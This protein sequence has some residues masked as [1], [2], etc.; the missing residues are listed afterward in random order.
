MM[1][2]HHNRKS[3]PRPFLLRATRGTRRPSLHASTATSVEKPTNGLRES[4]RNGVRTLTVSVLLRQR[5]SSR[6][7][8]DRVPFLRV[9]GQWLE[10]CGFV[11]GAQYSVT[12]TPGQLMLT[13]AEPDGSDERSAA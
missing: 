3:K 1:R 7:G 6:G 12:A 11:I 10:Q 8:H 5:S 13:L 4:R 2:R 9:S